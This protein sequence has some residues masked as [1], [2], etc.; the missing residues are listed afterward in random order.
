[1]SR[2]TLRE[3]AGVSE[4]EAVRVVL[5]EDGLLDDVTAENVTTFRL[6]F[7]DDDHVWIALS[8][9][10]GSRR[11]INLVSSAVYTG[12]SVILPTTEVDA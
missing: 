8:F 10:D 11:V 4:A 3:A 6:E 12:P 9:A 1:M 7:M 5:D 2:D